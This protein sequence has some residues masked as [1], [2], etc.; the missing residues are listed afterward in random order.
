MTD[1]QIISN[2]KQTWKMLDNYNNFQNFKSKQQMQWATRWSPSR[3]ALCSLQEPRGTAG[4]SSVMTPRLGPKKTKRAASRKCSVFFSLNPCTA[5]SW[6]PHI[7]RGVPRRR[8]HSARSTPQH[9]PIVHPGSDT[10][11]CALLFRS[12]TKLIFVPS[13]QENVGTK[14]GND[15]LP[16]VTLLAWSRRTRS[17][18]FPSAINHSGCHLHK[19]LSATTSA[20][21]SVLSFHN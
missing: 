18:S 3:H 12:E 20:P 17:P 5:L 6:V 13:A 14:A 16:V 1:K 19:P 2:L 15:S 8:W 11:L 4:Y 10:L 9:S 7:S 21:L